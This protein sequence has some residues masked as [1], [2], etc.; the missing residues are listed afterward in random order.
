MTTLS[1]PA[2]KKRKLNTNAI[3]ELD[4]FGTNANMNIEELD[5]LSETFNEIQN[6]I[7]LILRQMNSFSFDNPDSH[8]VSYDSFKFKNNES[9]SDIANNY[10]HAYVTSNGNQKRDLNGE[11]S[12]QSSNHKLLCN[13]VAKSDKDMQ[14]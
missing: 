13:D 5:H 11:I 8:D 6:E 10:F 4:V 9:E 12:L 7:R 14:I 2:Y 1:E 3:E